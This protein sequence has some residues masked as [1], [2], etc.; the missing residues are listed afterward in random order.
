MWLSGITAMAAMSGGRELRAQAVPIVH[1][2][3]LP[4]DIAAQGYYADELGYFKKAGLSVT[5]LTMQSAPVQASAVIGGSIDFGTSSFTTIAIARERGV[6]FVCV[7]P[8]AIYSSEQGAAGLV[9]SRP[10]SIRA[11]ADLNGK[12][13]ATDAIKNLSTVGLHAWMDKNGG[14]FGSV[15]FVELPFAEMGPAVRAAR[16]DAAVISQPTL[17]EALSAGGLQVIAHPYDA[18]AKSFLLGA[19]Y[20]TAAYAGEHP[21]VVTKF[22]AVMRD[23]A[24]WANANQPAS[25]KILEKY[26]K[27]SVTAATPRVRYAE[28]FR[29][30]EMQPLIDASAKYGLLQSTFP[31][32]EMLA[33]GIPFT[34]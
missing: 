4:I 25:A 17:T 15:R 23:T 32:A 19:F 12:T 3:E 6:K 22:A 27:I 30:S 8:A 34:A 7:A 16:V 1:V 28:I 10:S 20:T 21:D 33:P 24:R 31:A 5:I 2:G 29:L 13:V 26:T 14:D 18:I 11:A 9:V